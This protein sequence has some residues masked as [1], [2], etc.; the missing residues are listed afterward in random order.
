MEYLLQQGYRVIPVNPVYAT[1][2]ETVM[3]Q[4]VY[5]NLADVPVPID[6]VD[7][8][9]YVFCFVFDMNITTLSSIQ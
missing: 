7:I 2:G 5:A 8:F 4:V 3:G 1:K 6:M 9:R